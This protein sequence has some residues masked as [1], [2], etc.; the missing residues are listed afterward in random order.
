M[1]IGTD[2]RMGNR[3]PGRPVSAPLPLA[4][5]RPH[6]LNAN[7]RAMK[8]TSSQSDAARPAHGLVDEGSGTS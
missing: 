7:R 2:R 4:G 5:G 6:T 8:Y 1:T 3:L